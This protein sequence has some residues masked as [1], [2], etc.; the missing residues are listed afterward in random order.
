MVTSKSKAKCPKSH[1]KWVSEVQRKDEKHLC[2]L[3]LG[4]EMDEQDQVGAL[5]KKQSLPWKAKEALQMEMMLRL[6]EP[7]IKMCV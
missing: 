7:G 5:E 2:R 3:V 6:G 1:S 4:T